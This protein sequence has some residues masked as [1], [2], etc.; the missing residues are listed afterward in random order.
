MRESS[1]EVKSIRKENLKM[2]NNVRQDLPKVK[3]RVH[4]NLN[5]DVGPKSPDC[6]KNGNQTNI[7]G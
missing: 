7:D 2:T 6:R 5:R 4:F 1:E 3:K